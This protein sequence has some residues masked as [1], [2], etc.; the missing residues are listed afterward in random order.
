M[1]RIKKFMRKYD[2]KDPREVT[3]EEDV[4]HEFCLSAKLMK[5]K[6][7]IVIAKYGRGVTE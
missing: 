3:K 5:E 1:K 7:E 4:L 6:L 2:A